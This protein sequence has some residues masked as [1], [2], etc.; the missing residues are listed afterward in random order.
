M[1]V[2]SRSLRLPPQCRGIQ[3]GSETVVALRV[4]G[5]LMKNLVKRFIRD[6]PMNVV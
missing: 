1:F 3:T 2:P 4:Q 5:S 6:E